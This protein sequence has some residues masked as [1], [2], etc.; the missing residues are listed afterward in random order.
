LTTT[1]T[2]KTASTASGVLSVSKNSKNLLAWAPPSFSGGLHGPSGRGRTR[3]RATTKGATGA[4]PGTADEANGY[5]RSRRGALW[6]RPGGTLL[7][8]PGTES[9]GYGSW[10]QAADRGGVLRESLRTRTA[11]SSQNNR[12]ACF[13]ER[14]SGEARGPGP[15]GPGAPCGSAVRERRAGAPCGSAHPLGNYGEVGPMPQRQVR[16]LRAAP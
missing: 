11:R 12:W 14:L 1:T 16:H 8:P 10:P 5:Q 13:R 9:G 4:D 7:A 6:H 2:A 15:D 3:A